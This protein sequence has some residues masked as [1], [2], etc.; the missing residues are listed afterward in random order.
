MPKRPLAPRIFNKFDDYLLRNRPDTWST[1]IHLVIYYAILFS[2]ALA[3]ISFM[4]PDNPLRE[5]H[6]GFWATSQSVLVIVGIVVWIF[7]LVRFNTFKSFGTIHPGDRIKTYFFFF[8]SLVMMCLT[9]L[10]PPV[11]ET[12][13]TMIRYSPEQVADDVNK[14]NILL[15]QLT[16]DESP[17]EITVDSIFIV[18]TQTYIPPSSD[19]SYEW[20]DSLGAYVKK[21]IYLSKYELQYTL[22]D[23]DSVVWISNDKLLRFQCSSLRFVGTNDL[24]EDKS[25]H[26]FSNFEIYN[27][28][29]KNNVVYDLQVL[30]KEYFKIADKYI[31]P[32][33]DDAYDYFNST[34]SNS[35]S[36]NYKTNTVDEGI[37]H[38][39]SRLYRWD[40]DE[41]TAFAHIIYYVAMFL[42]LCLF[43][44]RHS[45][46]KTFFLS[47]LTGVIIAIVTGI[48]AIFLD[49]REKGLLITMLVYF[50]FFLIFSLSAIQSRTRSVFSGIALNLAVICTP[51]IPF[52]CTL[53]YYQFHVSDVIYDA[54]MSYGNSTWQ[55]ARDREYMFYQISEAAGFV[56]L[57]IMI[58]TV[59]KWM[60]RKWYAAPEE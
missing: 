44:F 40:G 36:Y 7:Y 16:K 10:I 48:I 56:V 5:S 1:R 60:Y 45:T 28:V 50:T 20:N 4:I 55:A 53:L 24:E 38:I 23:D 29:Y 52:I 43:I 12:Y 15:A 59:Y 19:D 8:V 14:M 9:V 49:F 32:Y 47:I 57:L 13:K 2:I 51:F 41:T 35:S 42:A 11:I 27:Q 6:V 34:L 54:Y 21:P 30:Q 39:C 25:I 31:D 33:N 17:A 3:A 22:S 37:R 18:D 46:M 26:L 58:E